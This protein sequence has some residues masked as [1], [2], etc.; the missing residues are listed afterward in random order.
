MLKLKQQHGVT[1]IELLIA[2]VIAS[3]LAMLALPA[4]QAMLA[5]TTQLKMV[6]K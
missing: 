3:V 4:F 2:L 6:P 5:S 1:L